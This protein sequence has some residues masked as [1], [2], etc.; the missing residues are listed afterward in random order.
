[1]L[2]KRLLT[3]G[4]LDAAERLV[5]V[6]HGRQRRL[7]ATRLAGQHAEGLAEHQRHAVQLATLRLW[8]AEH[9][10]DH[11]QRTEDGVHPE[12]AR[13]RDDLCEEMC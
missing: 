10:E 6:T 11:A 5:A 7:A 1:M 3:L 12:R 8:H 9:D 4:G 2:S 13:R